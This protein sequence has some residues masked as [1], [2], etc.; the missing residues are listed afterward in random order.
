MMENDFAVRIRDAYL[1]TQIE[2]IGA[3]LGDVDAAYGVQEANTQIWLQRGRRLSGRKIGLTARVVQEQLGVDQPDYGMLFE[4]MRVEIGDTL[5]ME[6]LL[7]P[8]AE[9]EIAFVINRTIDDPDVTFVELM[10]GVEY[11]LPAIEIVDSRILDWQISLNDTIADNASSAKYLIGARPVA[12]G[13]ISMTDVSMT[14]KNRD[15]V[16]SQGTGSACLG[17]PLNAVLWLAKTMAAS[18]RPLSENDTVLSGALGPMVTIAKD[19]TFVC[20]IEGFEPLRLHVE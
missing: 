19:D 4:D 18:G 3:Q 2:P 1:G 5:K 16:V 12:L 14:L 10:R 13:D 20:E 8:K 15:E 9:A 7:Q 11:A 6:A 17:H